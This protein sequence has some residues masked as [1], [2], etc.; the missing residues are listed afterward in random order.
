MMCY[1]LWLWISFRSCGQVECYIVK[2]E[3]V[4][5][6]TAFTIYLSICTF[7]A[8]SAASVTAGHVELS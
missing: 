7:P 8:L 2:D 3:I 4:F 5:Y 1:L 6:A